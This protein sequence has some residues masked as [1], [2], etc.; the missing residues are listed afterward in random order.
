MADKSKTMTAFS[1]VNAK[2]SL[3]RT[4]EAFVLSKPKQSEGWHLI[5]AKRRISSLATPVHKVYRF[6]LMICNSDELIIST[7][8]S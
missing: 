4:T 5:G 1:Y 7:I 8:S 6:G 3:S 2:Q